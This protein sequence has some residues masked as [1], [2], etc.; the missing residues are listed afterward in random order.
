MDVG[1]SN[2][3]D[4]RAVNIYTLGGLTP[5]GILFGEKIENEEDLWKFFPYREQNIKDCTTS[6]DPISLCS[7]EPTWLIK[8]KSELENTAR[9][10]NNWDGYGSPPLLHNLR[11]NALEFL[12]CLEAENIPTPYIG[13]ISGGGVQLEWH[14]EGRELEIE[15]MDPGNIG[16]LKK[17][18]S[19]SPDEGEFNPNDFDSARKIIKWLASGIE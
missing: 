17:Y 12:K 1:T 2:L 5:V 8:A 13:P 15:F 18:E 14:F 16:Y 19:G 11:K 6:D 10:P 9:L 7:S 4:D 3:L